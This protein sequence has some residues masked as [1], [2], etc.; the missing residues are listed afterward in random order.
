M[1]KFFKTLVLL[2]AALTAF[3]RTPVLAQ[4]A[5]PSNRGADYRSELRV[6]DER[7]GNNDDAKFTGQLT[8]VPGQQ[9]PSGIHQIGFLKNQGDALEA[10]DAL[11]VSEDALALQAPRYKFYLIRMD[12]VYEIISDRQ[13]FVSELC[14]ERGS[15]KPS[16]VL[17]AFRK[18]R[19][20]VGKSLQ[21]VNNNPGCQAGLDVASGV[22]QVLPFLLEA[23]S[24][25][26]KQ[27]GVDSTQRATE[28]SKRGSLGTTRGSGTG[29]DTRG[30]ETRGGA[31]LA[32][33]NGAASA[34]LNL[35]DKTI[36]LY[37]GHA[38]DRMA[39]NT[40]KRII[41]DIVTQYDECK[42]VGGTQD[43]FECGNLVSGVRDYLPR[44]ARD[45]RPYACKTL[46]QQYCAYADDPVLTNDAGGSIVNNSD[47][48]REKPV[49]ASPPPGV[50]SVGG[51]SPGG[52]GHGLQYSSQERREAMS[53]GAY[54]TH[55]LGPR[56]R[57]QR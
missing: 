30:V 53:D 50:D 4:G 37:F 29:G 36:C 2:G 44:A 42:A 31:R 6:Y 1:N 51:N 7:Y 40:R 27:G 47:C 56:P 16:R 3:L 55:H 26:L 14:S 28:E 21:F 25:R 10:L 43:F 45:P 24:E 17:G 48:I 34:S 49:A 22:P 18:L 32:S 33:S 15:G 23:T 46:R 19:T 5:V 52:S 11:D 54:E 35:L 13:R 9:K 20:P 38:A 57:P 8:Y 12:Y 41:E 39:H